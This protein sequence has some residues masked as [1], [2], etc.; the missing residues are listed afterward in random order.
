MEEDQLTKK[1]NESVFRETIEIPAPTIPV[2][3]HHR[4]TALPKPERRKLISRVWEMRMVMRFQ[5]HEIADQLKI[6]YESVKWYIRVARSIYNRQHQSK[7][8]YQ[9]HRIEEF[10]VSTEKRIQMLYGLYGRAG[11]RPYKPA[12]PARLQPEQ[13]EILPNT[14]LQKEILKEIREEEKQLIVLG[15]SLGKIRRIAPPNPEDAQG[16]Q[17][18]INIINYQ[19]QEINFNGG[20]EQ[21]IPTGGEIPILPAQNGTKGADHNTDPNAGL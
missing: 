13:K 14:D 20:S 4:Y 18:T 2:K 9:E 8:E 11:G 21:H 7:E 17:V 6:P 16:Q 12:D 15:Q 3:R 10:I 5:V 19:P 1:T